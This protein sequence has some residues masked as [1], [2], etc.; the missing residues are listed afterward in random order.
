MYFPDIRKKGC[1]FKL[2]PKSFKKSLS[3]GISVPN[4]LNYI[5]ICSNNSEFIVR[6]CTTFFTVHKQKISKEWSLSFFTNREP[7]EKLI[8]ILNPNKWLPC[9]CNLNMLESLNHTFNTPSQN[10]VL[11]VPTAP[12]KNFR[13]WSAV[14]EVIVY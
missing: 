9:R 14:I 12:L 2:I 11:L 4:I 7:F 10:N 5:F 6:V 8:K 1:L 3:F 13:L